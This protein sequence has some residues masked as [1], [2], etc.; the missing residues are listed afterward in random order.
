MKIGELIILWVGGLL[1]VAVLVLTN[2]GPT[3]PLGL[4]R[5]SGSVGSVIGST[6]HL[7][8]IVISIWIL[9]ALVWLTIYKRIR[10]KGKATSAR[11]TQQ[12]K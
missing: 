2:I 1:S 6:I 4:G 11:E 9:C 12:E 8:G 10:S 3:D 5:Y 7:I